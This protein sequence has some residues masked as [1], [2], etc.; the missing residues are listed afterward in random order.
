[1]SQR[2]CLT[3]AGARFQRVCGRHSI[4]RTATRTTFAV[5]GMAVTVL[6]LKGNNI[7]DAC[8]YRRRSEGTCYVLAGSRAGSRGNSVRP[9]S[10]LTRENF[11]EAGKSSTLLA[12]LDL[13]DGR[14]EPLSAA[15]WAREF[16]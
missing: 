14:A 11:L 1:M 2:W 15:D 5:A 12:R 6:P 10:R 16:L 3:C 4:A 9:Q 7:A 8:S 13:R